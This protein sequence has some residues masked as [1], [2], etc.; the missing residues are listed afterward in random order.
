M[1]VNSGR[2]NRYQS[3]FW[4]RP[5]INVPPI[6]KTFEGQFETDF[7]PVVWALIELCTRNFGLGPNF[8]IVKY[9]SAPSDLSYF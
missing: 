3:M 2:K 7:Y 1:H 9:I 6:F 5:H 8:G 4:Y